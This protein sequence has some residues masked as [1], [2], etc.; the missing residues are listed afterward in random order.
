MAGLVNRKSGKPD[1]RH[2]I[3]RNSG[4][5]ELRAH[6]HLAR[7]RKD[8]DVRDNSAFTR[9]HSASKT[10]VC[11]L[12]DALCPRMTVERHKRNPL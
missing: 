2:F 8:V 12:M 5:P 6:P 4:T 11:A 9:V 1:S 10:R 3:V 7:G